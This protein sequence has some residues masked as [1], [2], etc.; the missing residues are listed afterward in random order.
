MR[1][2]GALNFGHF[3]ILDLRQTGLRALRNGQVTEPDFYLLLITSFD[4]HSALHVFRLQF[5][6]CVTLVLEIM[7]STRRGFE[8]E[9]LV[10]LLDFCSYCFPFWHSLFALVLTSICSFLFSEGITEFLLVL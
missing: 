3:D 10:K 6:W 4:D 1:N 5:S 9:T 2:R 8:L 7:H